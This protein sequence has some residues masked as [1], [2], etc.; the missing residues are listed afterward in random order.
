V[1]DERVAI[2]GSEVRTPGA[3]HRLRAAD[4]NEAVE[5]TLVI[6]R[7]AAGNQVVAGLT[8]GR[9]H[10]QTREQI[11]R[12]LSADP[13]DVRAVVDFA[14]GNGLAI[15]QESAER[16][17]VRVKGSVRQMSAAFGIQLGYV[18]KPG[19]ERFLSYNGP[20]TAPAS[21]AALITAVLGLHQE[22]VARPHTI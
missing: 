7:S 19:G 11:E 2:S 3:V 20:L 17:A 5:A 9:A 22:R 15:V 14:R 6:R 12:Q 18:D 16:R 1:A 4:P 13:G 8:S 21:I 10:S